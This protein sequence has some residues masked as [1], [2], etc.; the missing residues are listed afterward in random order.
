MSRN[1]RQLST[2]IFEYWIQMQLTTYVQTLLQAK[3]MVSCLDNVFVVQGLTISL[4][5]FS[6]NSYRNHTNKSVRASLWYYC[7]I[8]VEDCRK[9]EKKYV[10]IAVW[11]AFPEQLRS[12]TNSKGCPQKQFNPL[13]VILD[14]FY[15]FLS[16]YSYTI[17]LIYVKRMQ[18]SCCAHISFS[19]SSSLIRCKNW[20]YTFMKSGLSAANHFVKGCYQME[21]CLVVLQ[22]INNS[23]SGNHFLPSE[24]LILH[25][26]IAWKSRELDI[27]RL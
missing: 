16:S 8:M 19:L 7:V 2:P 15:F 27:L 18:Y 12:V 20:K 23:T 14:S 11:K 1:M 21:P 13:T 4:F 24:Q 22:I 9:K 3:S 17:I 6:F 26:L 25:F 10:I 5:T